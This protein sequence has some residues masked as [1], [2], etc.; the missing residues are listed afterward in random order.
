[1]E[2]LKLN[3]LEGNTLSRNELSQLKGLGLKGG[4]GCGCKYESEGGATTLDNAAANDALGINPGIGTTQ[5]LP[6]VVITE[7]EDDTEA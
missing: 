4:C 3:A 5:T 1:M 2:R 6:E 7:E